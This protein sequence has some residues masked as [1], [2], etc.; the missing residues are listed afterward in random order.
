MWINDFFRCIW[1]DDA[2]LMSKVRATD[3]PR[4]NRFFED[5]M[6]E[7]KTPDDVPDCFVVIEDAGDVPITRASRRVEE[8]RHAF[9]VRIATPN[10][11]LTRELARLYLAHCEQRFP[12]SRT[13]EGNVHSW[14]L[15]SQRF[16]TVGGLRL[17]RGQITV[18]VR[19]QR[20]WLTPAA[21]VA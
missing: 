17:W 14:K 7:L 18:S 15:E 20:S 13:E 9:I 19:K 11:A 21:V 5:G 12:G 1:R 16:D 8:R 3:D 10:K 6:A 2:Y 4:T